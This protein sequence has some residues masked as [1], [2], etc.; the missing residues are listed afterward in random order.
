MLSDVTTPQDLDDRF[1]EAV[2]G[3]V[4]PPRCARPTGRSTTAP[5]SPAPAPWSCSTPSSPA[6]TSTSPRAGCAAS[7]RASTRSARP[8]TRATRR[9]P[10]PC[11]PTDPALLHYRS[12][13]VLL[14]PG[15]PGRRARDP[16]R[17]RAARRRRLGRG[18]D[19]RRPAQGLRP[20]RPGHHPDHLH[21]R[22][23]PAP[24]GR[25]RLRHRAAPRPPGGTGPARRRRAPGAPV[26]RLAG[27]R[28]RGLLVRRRLG[29]PRQRHRRVQHRRLV[30]PHRRCG[31]RCCSSAR[32]T[33]WASAS[34]PRTAGWPPRCAPGPGIRYFAADGCDLAPTYDAATRGRRL[35]PP[36]TAARP[37]CTC[38]WSG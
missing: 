13:G 14:R 22:L 33:G 30:R 20:R 6:A 32:T 24:R 19:R 12:G 10:R 3:L 2:G 23:A 1:R 11:A 28:D 34:A 26:R 29:Q 21:D 36:S 25:P 4:A 38:A 27:G 17:R 16:I 35:G 31:C 18:A 37:C 9:S 5:R 8:A 7:A 15:G